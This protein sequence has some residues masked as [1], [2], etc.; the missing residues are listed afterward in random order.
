MEKENNNRKEWLYGL[1]LALNV[2]INQI[3]NYIAAIGAINLLFSESEIMQNC[4]LCLSL[5]ALER[6]LI[7]ETSRIFD[8]ACTNGKRNCTLQ[9]LQRVLVKD[10]ILEKDDPGVTEIDSLYEKYENVISRK[11]RNTKIAHHSWESVD[12]MQ[13]YEIDFVSLKNLMDDVIQYMSSISDKVMKGTIEPPDL[14]RRIEAYEL[15]ISLLG[16]K[17]KQDGDKVTRNSVGRKESD[18]STENVSI[19]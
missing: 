17:L 9:Y 2:D 7:T 8:R 19:Y 4:Y 18:G 5:E 14:S 13:C 15:S 12:A 3:I 10:G 6:N 1:M 16:A 11:I